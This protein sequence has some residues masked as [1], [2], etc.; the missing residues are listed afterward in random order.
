M[1]LKSQVGSLRDELKRIREDFSQSERNLA[2]SRQKE[3]NLL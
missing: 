3:T 1:D 2:E